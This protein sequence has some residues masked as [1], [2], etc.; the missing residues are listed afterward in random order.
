MQQH[1]GADGIIRDGAVYVSGKNIIE[2]GP[3]KDLKA[4][5][6]TAAVIGSPRF[7]VMPGF[8]NAHQHGKG[9]TNF[10]LGGLDDCF[11]ISR[12]SP[13]PLASIDPYID[14]LYGCMRM[15]ESGVTTCIH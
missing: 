8:V 6:P 5:Y 7:W 10:Q 15:I 9:L 2:V 12:F 14:T 4:A 3:Y 1:L 11:E 13:E